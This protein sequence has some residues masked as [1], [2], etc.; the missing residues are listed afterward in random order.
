MSLGYPM[1]LPR[2]ERRKNLDLIDRIGFL[3]DD[4]DQREAQSARE[5]AALRDEMRTG[6]A[7]CERDS[8]AVYR[9]L[10]AVAL[11]LMTVMGGVIA[12]L[13]GAF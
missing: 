5:L 1:Q 6:F 11:L 10:W 3:E 9:L 7:K 4:E 8:R 2:R 12:A 13:M